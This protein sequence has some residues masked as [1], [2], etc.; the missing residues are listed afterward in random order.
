MQFI[1]FTDARLYFKWVK[2]IIKYMGL[3]YHGCT[4]H[5]PTHQK[6]IAESSWLACILSSFK[7]ANIMEK[8]LVIKFIMYTSQ[9]HMFEPNSWPIYKTQNTLKFCKCRVVHK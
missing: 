4:Q 3:I 5:A 7:I 1:F 2:G 9:L 6:T 8:V